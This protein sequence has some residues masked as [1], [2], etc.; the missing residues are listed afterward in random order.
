MF[1]LRNVVSRKRISVRFGCQIRQVK[2]LGLALHEFLLSQAK[3]ILKK[4]ADASHGASSEQEFK[5]SLMTFSGKGSERAGNTNHASGVKVAVPSFSTTATKP[6]LVSMEFS[7]NFD[8]LNLPEIGSTVACDGKVQVLA[9]PLVQISLL[10]AADIKSLDLAT[11][12]LSA[13]LIFRASSETV[14]GAMC[15]FLTKSGWSQAGMENPAKEQVLD[16]F[17]ITEVTGTWCA[18]N[19]LSVFAILRPCTFLESLQADGECFDLPTFVALIGGSALCF[20]CSFCGLYATV[21]SR[22]VVGGKLQLSDIRGSEHEVPFQVRRPSKER[23]SDGKTLVTW[24]VQTQDLQA[25]G[26]SVNDKN[27][28]LK[29]QTKFFSERNADS[30]SFPI[31]QS[32]SALSFPEPSETPEKE[33]LHACPALSSVVPAALQPDLHCAQEI[34]AP[35]SYV[36]FF[37][38]THQ[39]WAHGSIEGPGHSHDFSGLPLYT[40][41]LNRQQMRYLIPAERLRLPFQTGD[42]ISVN[43]DEQ[44]HAAIVLGK[45][46]WPLAYEVQFTTSH[47]A[48]VTCQQTIGSFVGFVGL[49]LY[50][51]VAFF[52]VFP[53]S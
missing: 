13:P 25:S 14:Q 34:F 10:D 22:H 43:V 37:S 26:F 28:F 36:E 49:R 33:S 38:E 45:R 1:D 6:W 9:G 29:L 8:G 19:H 18:T 7:Q 20:C 17:N 39:K 16:A 15:T 11:M 52:I 3:E 32:G 35:R 21:K 5:L 27:R 40:I 23:A 46:S 30:T 53:R 44:W 51:Q 31:R 50:V 24:D 48:A 47:E 41:R 42:N 4:E 12:N 2:E